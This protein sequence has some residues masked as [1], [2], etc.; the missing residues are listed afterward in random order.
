MEYRPLGNTGLL[1]SVIGLGC[2]RLGASVFEANSTDAQ[3][4]LHFAIDHGINFFDT[5]DSYGYGNSERVLGKAFRGKRDKVILATKGGFLPSSLA[6]VGQYLVPFIGPFR[7]RISRKKSIFKTL[8]RKRQNFD[9]AYLKKALEQSLK[10]LSTDYLDLYQLHSPPREVLEHDDVFRFLEQ[11]Q[12]EGKIRFYGISVNTVEDGLFCLHHPHIAALQ[13]PI[14]ILEHH[15]TTALLPKVL[16]TGVIARVPLARG[17]LTDR[18]QVTT[19]PHLK[20]SSQ[21]QQQLKNLHDVCTRERRN[22]SQI[23]IQLLLQFTQISS[24]IVGTKSIEHLRLNILAQEQPALSQDLLRLI[25]I[26][27]KS[28]KHNQ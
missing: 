22:I 23:A 28:S 1:T 15:A 4:L 17:L 26:L 20:D 18:L 5:A 8:S 9:V 7:S 24:I 25:T 10:R 13:V 19:G 3:C 11:S 21:A 14:N 6:R 12:Q 16:Q 27:N 2:S